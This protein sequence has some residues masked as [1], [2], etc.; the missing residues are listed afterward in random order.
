MTADLGREAVYAAEVAAF[1]GTAFES[2]S[3]MADLLALA[4]VITSAPWWPHGAIEVVAARRDAGSSSARRRGA[5]DPVVRL[6]ATQMTPATLVHEFAHVLAGIGEGHGAT[7]RRAH[8]DLV[9]FVFGD[10]PASW[11]LDAY[12]AMGLAP[13]VR[14]WP[15]PPVRW[16]GGGPVAL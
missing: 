10:E 5:G 6:A 14:A 2:L 15:V 8:V 16:A 7:F 4:E 13:G 9:G 3:A 1:E 11:L 12:A